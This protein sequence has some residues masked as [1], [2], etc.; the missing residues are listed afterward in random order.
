MCEDAPG[1]I[2]SASG[3]I[4]ESR[5]CLGRDCSLLAGECLVPNLRHEIGLNITRTGLRLTMA[6]VAWGTPLLYSIRR[7]PAR[8]R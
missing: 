7:N 5:H 2:S 8:I 6:V 3:T 1:L 4:P